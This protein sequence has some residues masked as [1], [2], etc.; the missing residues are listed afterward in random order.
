MRRCLRHLPVSLLVAAA[1]TTLQGCALGSWAAAVFSP[2]MKDP[3]LF[4]IPKGKTILVLPDD[5]ESV[6]TYDPAR[7]MLAESLNKLL[8]ENKVATTT[9]PFS[10]LVDL[11]A[12]TNN[13]EDLSVSEIGEK[14]GAD[15]VVYVLFDAFSLKDDPGNPLWHGRL[16]A[17]VRVVDVK[18]GLLWPK[19]R[20]RDGWPIKPV[21]I[22]T[23]NTSV[24]YEQVLSRQLT[25]EAAQRIAW[26]FY[27]HP[28]PRRL[29]R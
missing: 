8:V 15:I 4:E 9:I 29:I 2:P 26:L 20:P 1:A 28:S 24:T 19:D 10:N 16:A 11:D 25:A 27:E 3:A 13:L 18:G 14:L 5:F 12:R 6:V 21:D 22:P 7:G 17:N 23:N